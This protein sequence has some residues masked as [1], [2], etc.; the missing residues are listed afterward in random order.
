MLLCLG[1]ALAGNRLTAVSVRAWYLS[2]AQPPGAPPATAFVPVWALL[3]LLMTVAAWL[4]WRHPDLRGR[5]LGLTAWGWQLLLGAAWTPLFFGL[6][7]LLPALCVGLGLVGASAVTV[8]LFRP[9]SL[10]AAMLLL[11]GLLWASFAAYL[12]AGFWWLNG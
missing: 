5:R 7:L 1:V 9:L 11:P 4:V 8:L 2:L 10:V 3:Y 12:N 6:H